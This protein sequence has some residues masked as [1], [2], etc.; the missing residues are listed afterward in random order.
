MI[1]SG[2][3]EP[4]RA[5]LKDAS[6]FAELILGVVLSCYFESATKDF[7]AAGFSREVVFTA[8]FMEPPLHCLRLVK[9]AKRDSHTSLE[10]G[11]TCLDWTEARMRKLLPQ[12]CD[13]AS[14]TA[15][16][17]QAQST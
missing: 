1:P 14:L 10:I 6:R 12:H 13:V 2:R 3:Y 16:F 17:T 8:C 11:N 9:L 4:A 15:T 5:T 7:A